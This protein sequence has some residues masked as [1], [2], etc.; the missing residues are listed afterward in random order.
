MRQSAKSW[1]P[2][3]PSSCEYSV[4]ACSSNFTEVQTSEF[5]LTRTADDLDG[6]EAVPPRDLLVLSSAPLARRR[7]VLLRDRVLRTDRRPSIRRPLAGNISF[8][9]LRRQEIS[10][11]H[12]AAALRRT[13]PHFSSL[14]SENAISILFPA[15]VSSR[16]WSTG[17]AGRVSSPRAWQ[18]LRRD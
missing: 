12:V 1:H 7:V 10:Q 6:T 2:G 8:P 9:A 15:I 13:E 5:R 14:R 16:L 11:R 18:C 17:K 3:G 4:D